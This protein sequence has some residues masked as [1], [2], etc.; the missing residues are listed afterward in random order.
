MKITFLNVLILVLLSNNL[1]GQ[2]KDIDYIL[3][4]GGI[5]LAAT[6]EL[7]KEKLAPAEPNWTE[8]NPFDI[9]FRDFFKWPDSR[10]YNAH[11][12]SDIILWS[13]IIPSTFGAPAISGYHYNEHLLINIQVLAATGLLTGISKYVIAR[14][15]PYAYYKVDAGSEK[16][17][18]NLS[19]F[20]GHSA[21]AFAMATTT[22]ILLEKKFHHISGLIWSSTLTLAATTGILR[23]AA[24]RH[25]MS[26]VLTGT[27][28]GTFTAY[29]IAK[30][31]KKQMSY[32]G[33]I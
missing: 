14:Q 12:L 2:P 25:Y 33:H 28:V 22:S 21:I 17:K 29:L 4:Y 19:F 11:I 3:G 10:V 15:R 16:Y 9:Y 1:F 13:M 23:I 18:D 8:P 31:Q 26:D 20:S 27:V 24:D 6:N 30:N 7:F 5:A 32:F